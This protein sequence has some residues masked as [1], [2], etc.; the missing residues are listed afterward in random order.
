MRYSEI[1]QVLEVSQ[2]RVSQLH[3]DAIAK[4]RLALHGKGAEEAA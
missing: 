4:L 2:P 1:A 3:S